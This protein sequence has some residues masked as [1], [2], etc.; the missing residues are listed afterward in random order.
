MS[1]DG[2]VSI[3]MKV[4]SDRAPDAKENSD[5]VHIRSKG[6]KYETK[7]GKVDTDQPAAFQFAH[8]QRHVRWRRLR[9]DDTPAAYEIAGRAELVRQ[10]T[11]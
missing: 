5:L 6:V 11:A 7:T 10:R 3:V 1:S 4:P 9:S 8:G 2:E